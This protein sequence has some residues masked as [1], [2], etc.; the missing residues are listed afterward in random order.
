MTGGGAATL[1]RDG[2]AFDVRWAKAGRDAPLE[3]VDGDDAAVLKPGPTWIV[4]TY[5]GVLPR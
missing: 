3:L 4:L 1:L 5:G 2:R